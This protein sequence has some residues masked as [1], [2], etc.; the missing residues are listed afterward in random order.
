M[1]LQRRINDLVERCRHTELPAQPHGCPGEGL[2]LEPPAGHQASR[3][4]DG[5]RLLLCRPAK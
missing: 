5:W 2:Q 1:W 3:A 4:P